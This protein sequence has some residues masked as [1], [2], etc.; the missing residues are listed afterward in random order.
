MKSIEIYS[1]RTP[2]QVFQIKKIQ[3]VRKIISRK[4]LSHTSTFF[5]ISVDCFSFVGNLK[6]WH[7]SQ[8]K[9]DIRN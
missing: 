1:L 4:L 9:L 6:T 7:R 2:Y 8:I 5:L 3:L